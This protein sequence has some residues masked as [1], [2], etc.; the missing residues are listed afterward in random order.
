MRWRF[1]SSVRRIN[2]NL[3]H[4]LALNRHW[5][6]HQCQLSKHTFQLSSRI[7]SDGKIRRTK[8]YLVWCRLTAKAVAPNKLSS[9]I[10]GKV[11]QVTWKLSLSPLSHRLKFVYLT[12]STRCCP[13]LFAFPS[14]KHQQSRTSRFRIS[15]QR[16][17][18][19]LGGE[20]EKGNV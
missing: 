5:A 16:R 19:L 1:S 6:S 4:L 2:S 10:Y 20:I 15:R 9:N 14:T 8:C 3:A 11:E 12:C 13:T 18:K 17:L 7:A